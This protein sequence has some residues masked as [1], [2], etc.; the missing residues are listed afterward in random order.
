MDVAEDLIILFFHF[1]VSR[2]YLAT[3]LFAIL[4]ELEKVLFKY[5]QVLLKQ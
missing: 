1:P 3:S 5:F 2:F 4:K